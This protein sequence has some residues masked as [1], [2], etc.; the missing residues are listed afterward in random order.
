MHRIRCYQ[1][2]LHCERAKNWR[3]FFLAEHAK[4]AQR[5]ARIANGHFRYVTLVLA[6]VC[7]DERAPQCRCMSEIL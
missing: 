4:G 5:F 3:R 1:K 7:K 2:L 6:A